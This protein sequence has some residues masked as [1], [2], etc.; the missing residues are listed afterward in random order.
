MKNII[1]QLEMQSLRFCT[2]VF[3]VAVVFSS[4]GCG[5]GLGGGNSYFEFDSAS[6]TIIGYD[7]DGP[8]NVTLPSTIDGIQVTAIGKNAFRNKQ[9]TGVNILTSIT[10]IGE[11]AFAENKLTSVIVLDS[12]ITIGV[13]A[14]EDNL[15]ETVVIPN[16]IIIIGE[17]A[18]ANNR[19][20]SVTIGSSV[21]S[22]GNEAFA[23]NQLSDID[24]PNSVTSIGEDAFS[25]NLLTSITIGP[26]KNYA[27]HIVPNFGAAYNGNGKQA[28]TYMWVDSSTWI[29]QQV[30]VGVHLV[31]YGRIKDTP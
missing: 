26:N 13:S 9:L 1:N 25:G 11:G 15:L 17:K 28:G 30:G 16:S 23:I 24:I 4:I 21:T 14:F 27:S 22:I 29:K 6:G 5:V 2:I 19:L 20:T 18:F 10:A 7:D 31:R 8:K 12:V 3:V